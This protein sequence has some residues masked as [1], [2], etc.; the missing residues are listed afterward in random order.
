VCVCV[1]VCVCVCVCVCACVCVCVYVCHRVTV[2]VLEKNGYGVGGSGDK[3]WYLRVMPSG[4]WW[5]LESNSDSV[6]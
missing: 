2:K 6:G 3:Y 4:W 5:V 1:R